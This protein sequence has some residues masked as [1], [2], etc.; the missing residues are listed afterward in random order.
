MTRLLFSVRLNSRCSLPGELPAPWWSE[1]VVK[2]CPSAVPVS[3]LVSIHPLPLSHPL[4]F[5]LS[6]AHSA[7]EVLD[8]LHFSICIKKRQLRS[9][10]QNQCHPHIWW[11]KSQLD[12]SS[13]T[14]AVLCAVV[15]HLCSKAGGRS[16]ERQAG[17]LQ[18]AWPFSIGLI[19]YWYIVSS[20]LI[21]DSHR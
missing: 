17:G 6:P 20:S 21:K 16:M 11:F 5:H 4:F 1:W 3:H 15:K 2:I 13:L 9:V 12:S 18:W 14:A 8:S 19:N 10:L 7:D